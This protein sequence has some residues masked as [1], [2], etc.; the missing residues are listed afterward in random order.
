MWLFGYTPKIQHKFNLKRDD[1]IEQDLI[2]LFS[3]PRHVQFIQQVD[4]RSK[5]PPVYDQ[6]NLGSCT[7]NAIGAA[8][9]FRYMREFEQQE[10]K[11]EP[12]IPSRL[13]IYYNERKIEGTINEDSGASLS[14]GIKT[15]SNTGVCTETEWPYD[16]TVY[17]NEPPTECYTY[18][19][20]HT[21]IKSK[22]LIQDIT[23]LKTCLSNGF[24]FVFGLVIYPSFESSYASKTGII[25]VPG[26]KEQP[27]GGHALLCCGYDETKQVFIIRNSWGESWGDKGYCY[28]PYSY[29]LDKQKAHDFW[30]VE[31]VQNS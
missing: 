31:D 23:Q 30:T 6:G 15:I 29:I 27:L 13:F 24:P 8:Y 5:M 7:A 20:S 2:H 12:F 3:V 18:A 11:D 16:I 10:Q 17:K 26:P 25:P 4:L 9:Q 19:S 28:I 22:R 21:C 14:D 1:V